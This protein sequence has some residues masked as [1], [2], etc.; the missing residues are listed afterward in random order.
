MICERYATVVVPFPFSEVPV[1][2]RRPVAVLSGHT[3]N[4]ATGAT[5]C[6]M[7]TSSTSQRWPSDVAIAE[8]ASAGLSVPCTLRMRLATIPNELILRQ[9]G[10][11]GAVD[12]LACE[13]AFASITAD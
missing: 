11:L 1:L 13:A 10:N 12:R 7:I 6:A 8:L 3:F 4:A 9:I 2:K 5:L